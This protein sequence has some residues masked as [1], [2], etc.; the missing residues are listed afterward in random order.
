[1]NYLFLYVA[2]FVIITFYFD[3][4]KKMNFNLHNR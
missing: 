3:N 2:F 1:M 4:N